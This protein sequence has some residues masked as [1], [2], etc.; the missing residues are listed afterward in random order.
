MARTKRTHYV[1]AYDVADDGKRQKLAN[2]L[3]DYG[4]R[5]QKSVFEADLTRSEMKEILEK[6]S[7]YLAAEDSLR[8]YPLCQECQA[9]VRMQGRI[10][11]APPPSGRIV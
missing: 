7:K 11:P 1:I 8:L 5:V 6:A 3:L 10:L 9:E 2:L 4:D